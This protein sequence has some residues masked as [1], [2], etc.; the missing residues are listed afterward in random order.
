MKT[1]IQNTQTKRPFGGFYLL[2][3]LSFF[4][5]QCGKDTKQTMTGTQTSD[6]NFALSLPSKI[7]KHQNGNNITAQLIINGGSPIN[8]TIDL[9]NDQ[10]TA[11]TGELTPGLHSFVIQYFLDGA[12][13]TT[14]TSQ[15][16]IV[17]GQNTNIV[18]TPNLNVNVAPTLLVKQPAENATN[19]AISSSISATFSQPMDAS[20]I[21]PINFTLND[22]TNAVPGAV[23]YTESP[24][25]FEARFTPTESLALA[26]NYT[27][28]LNT[29]ISGI[30][31]EPLS[32]AEN[33]TFTTTDGTWG[34]PQ[35]VDFDSVTDPLNG[36]LTPQIAVSPASNAIAVW[37]QN[38]LGAPG[39][40]NI[41]ANRYI[42]NSGWGIP[43]LIETDDAGHAALPQITLDSSGNAIALWQHLGQSIYPKYRLADRRKT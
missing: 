5:I 23:A 33:W 19:V 34:N 24:P 38:N 36:T 20:S 22:L 7:K 37:V 8:M 29:G 13:I 35:G 25:N 31:G 15:A 17:A 11:T 43:E 21:I 42:K 6:G 10:V 18:F 14:A 12:L 3:I 2:L 30:L 26:A 27:A 9:D 40:N 28:N 1:P 39:P 41:W 32:A 16:Q 4:L